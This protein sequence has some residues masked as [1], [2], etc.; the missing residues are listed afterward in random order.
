[1]TNF[2]KFSD[3]TL[4]TLSDPTN[5]VVGVGGGLNF[6]SPKV[7]EWTTAN[8]PSPPFNGLLGYNTDLS[9]YEYWDSGTSEWFQLG[10][11]DTG[12]VTLVNTGTGL[13]GGPI[14]NSGTISFAP[15]AANSFW[16][17]TTGSTA[18]PTV[19]SLSAFLLAAN[20]LSDVPNKATARTN[21][22]LQIGVNVEA[23]SA[24]LDTIA[25]LGKV[26]LSL[27]GTNAALTAANGG[28]VYSTATS[29]AILSP[30]ATANQVLL[31][32]SNSAPAW[33]T[34]IYPATTTINQLLYS[35]GS[36][37]IS[38]LSTVNSAALV[39]T[40]SGVPEWVG[41]LTN[42]QLIIG[43]TGANPAVGVLTPGAN[44]TIVNGPGTITISASGALAAALTNTH[45]FVGNAAN[46][47]TDVALSGDATMANTGAITVSS[48][49]GVP[50]AP[51]AT[52]DTTN[53]SN[54]T[55][56]LLALSVG[57]T[58]ADLTASNGGIF[59]S[60]ATAG[61]I[62]AGTATARQMLQSGATAAPAWSTA[63]WPA[64]TTANQLLYSSATNTVA[65]LASAANS[66]L[67]TD[68]SSVPSLSQTLPTA[69]Q[70]N[71]TQLGTQTQALNMG[72][73]QINFMAD[74]SSPQDSATKNYVDNLVA[75]ITSIFVARLIST[76]NVAYTYN[77][78]SSGIGAT[79][80]AGS[81]G[82]VTIDGKTVVLNDVVLFQNQSTTYQNGLYGCT[83]DGSVTAA[84]FTRSTDYDQ[85]TEIRPGDLVV[86]T[87]GNAE[88]NTTWIETA[89][90]TN[91]GSD[92]ILFQQ[93][94]VALPISLSSGG[95]SASLTASNGGIVY[96][97]ASAMAILSGTATAGKV[98]QSGASSA[99]TWSTS[100]Y[101]TGSVT[102]GKIIISDGTNFIASTPTYPNSASGTGTILR[103]DG[104]NWSATTTTYPNTN[105][106]S[107]LLYASSANV[108]SALATANDGLLV[109][110]N[111]GVP[112]IL[113][114]PGT[115]GNVLQS[116]TSAAPSFSTATYPSVATGTGT[117][118]RADGTN[119][120]ATTSTY[121]NT[122]AVST[123]L[124]ASSANV[125]SALATANSGVL[126]TSGSGVPSILA[127]GTTGQIFQASSAGTPGWSTATY[128]AT[129]G[130]ARTILVSNATNFVNTT[131]TYA[132]PGTSGNV[133][134]SDGTNWTSAAPA[135]IQMT[136][137]T[138][139]SAT[140]NAAVNN[141]YVL[142]HAS[143]AC[144]V[145]L[146]ATAAVGAKIPF[147][148]LAGSGGWTITANTGQTIQFGNQSS[149]SGGSWSSSDAGDGCDLECIVANTTWYLSNAVSADLTK[150]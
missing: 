115:T 99:P 50:F 56:G 105:A 39:T 94:S 106:I 9:S 5:D 34:A 98:L 83:N 76:S 143:T 41:P 64:T 49:G 27:G 14:T 92:P 136:W 31:S 135:F 24:I 67:V 125:M 91:I 47:A 62:L 117:L 54:I 101:P 38:G 116:N 73:H 108:M 147:R 57:G 129:A 4:A 93:F 26:P 13:T 126:V 52:T 84:V 48:T 40:S 111:S 102:S 110:S 37:A 36:N 10:T 131:E 53:A 139:T 6:K 104:T 146:P 12:T 132:T 58:N 19:T 1:M 100:T 42:G 59:Y 80:T 2:V 33:S 44:V 81:S 127:A 138:I 86:I 65:G 148:G 82:S 75:A 20:N 134:T 71:I 88:K 109:T 15:I 89:T 133:M 149:S 103:A 3:F 79:L 96:S 130:T 43:S 85:P 97:T 119:W 17:N 45:I 29:F 137:S 16:A 23:W 150:V 55:S 140:L 68:G 60:T 8:R 124:Y 22:G 7:V 51:S 114:G 63:T 87:D 72:S 95:T 21:L 28:I 118:L 112:S 30:T 144:V 35:S 122:N 78:G 25:G 123:L 77:N 120:V 74:P 107:T 66:T 32:G 113:A 70:S 90:V 128:P 18:V 145:T 142:N 121:P 141:G 11:G 69:V 46:V 61:A